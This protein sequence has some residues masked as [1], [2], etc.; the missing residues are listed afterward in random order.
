MNPVVSVIMAVRDEERRVGLAIASVI[1]QTLSDSELIIVD[2]ASTDGTA[3]ALQS[4]AAADPRI[5]VLSS[6]KNLGR[7]Q[8]RNW[9]LQEARADLIAILDA[10]DMMMPARLERQVGFMAANPLV[11][12]LGAW[13]YYLFADVCQM[14]YAQPP[15][16][17]TTIRRR[18]ASR[19][20]PFIHPT[21]MFR[22]ELMLSSGGY[23]AGSS[24]GNEDLYTCIRLIAKTRAASMPEPLLIYSAHGLLQG[25]RLF[26]KYREI[27]E[28]ENSCSDR[29]VGPSCCISLLV[30]KL[31]VNHIPP[32]L[33]GTLMLERLQRWPKCAESEIRKI[34]DWINILN[35][36]RI[37]IESGQAL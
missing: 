13:A 16:D 8:A 26:D 11:G 32:S 20:M 37:E 4:F 19:I 29:S 5:L 6:S 30:R 27:I 21:M 24:Q 1:R 17:D 25:A 2:D 3:R 10:D 7:A 35:R 34:S 18:L 28:L 14:R 15:I 23:A 9:A 33:Y 31:I 22:R 12:M 36:V